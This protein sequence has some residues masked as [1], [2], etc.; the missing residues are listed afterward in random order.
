MYSTKRFPRIACAAVVVLAILCA[1]TTAWTREAVQVDT[2]EPGKL[3]L[4]VGKSVILKTVATIKRASVGNP[5]VADFVLLSPHELYVTGKAAG[6]TNLMLWSKNGLSSVFDVEVAYDITGLKEKLHQLLPDENNIRVM[7]THK[8]ITLSGTV[9][10]ASNVNQAVILAQAYAPEGNVKNALEVAGVQQVMLEVRVAEMQRSLIKRLG[11]NFAFDRSGDLGVGLLGGLTQVVRPENAEIFAGPVGLGVS[12]AVTALLRF[13][14][15]G[16]TWTGFI[17]ALRDDGL[18]KI[19]AE[20]TL[21]ALSGQTGSFLAGGEFPV[22]VPQGLGSTAI[23]YK[24]FGVGLSFT[25]TILGEKINLK[26][27]PE[28]SELDFSTA[29]R[30]E[31]FVVPGLTARR[32][33]T[34]VE[35]EDGQSFAIAG[36]LRETVRDT[37]S[38][39]PVLGDVP[40]IGAL[41]RSREFQ[42]GESELVIIVTPHLVKPLDVAKTS[43]PTDY[44]IEPNDWELYVEGLMEGRPSKEQ[45]AP[46]GKMEGQFG[47]EI[48]LVKHEK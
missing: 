13:E 34:V 26:V 21:I 41:F 3:Q 23:E 22:P 32:A 48:P 25:P 38:K 12:D 33:S 7:A 6:S 42:K 44:Y 46:R 43:L 24:P 5:E 37:M 8:S 40:V 20:P 14:K 28:V 27:Q 18:I 9:S 1:G 2:T 29:V 16:T 19:L 4:T 10:R 39:Y 35:L 36:L 15:N 30:L 11:M 47:H 45:S 17:D 31:G